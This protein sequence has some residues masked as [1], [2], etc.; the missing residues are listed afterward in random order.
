MIGAKESH[1][2]VASRHNDCRVRKVKSSPPPFLP[3]PGVS[4]VRSMGPSVCTSLPTSKTF[5]W[6]FADVTL[7]DDE[8]QLNT[9]DDANIKQS[10][11]IC[12]Q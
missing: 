11:A 3:D 2:M 10:L 9:I 8:Y 5:G 6:D 1:E 12:N 4:G 7:A